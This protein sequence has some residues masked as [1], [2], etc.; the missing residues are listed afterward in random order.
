MRARFLRALPLAIALTL[1]P[2]V[3]RAQQFVL[4]DV[5]FTFTKED[6]DTSEPSRSHYYVT[7]LDPE[8]PRDW[9]SPIDYRNGTVHIR[10]EVIHK[11]A[12]GEITQWVLCYI[13]NRGIGQGYGCTGTGTY[14]EEGVY[15]VDVGMRDW[16]ENGSIDWTQGI[17]EMHLVMKDSD[18]GGGF[19]HLRPD[20]EE[21]FPTTMRITMVQ[22]AAGATYDPSVIPATPGVTPD[23]GVPPVEEDAGTITEDDAGTA[24]S[25]PVDAGRPFDAGTEPTAPPPSPPAPG[26]SGTIHGGCAVTHDRR[27]PSALVLVLLGA[28]ALLRRRRR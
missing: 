11:P 20:P 25:D 18:S 4:I 26:A 6:A 14:T 9:T 13:P 10:T 16:W 7:D 5:M 12:G 2:D 28:V 24:P 27:D 17:R 15:D 23:A 22:V 19:A 3:A 8:R 21:F 1:A